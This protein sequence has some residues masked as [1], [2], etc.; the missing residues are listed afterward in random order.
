MRAI[1]ISR[2]E[3]ARSV[4]DSRGPDGFIEAAT[5]LRAFSSEGG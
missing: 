3:P 5:T 2:I 4:L 1:F